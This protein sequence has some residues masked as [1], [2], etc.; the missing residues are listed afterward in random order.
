[1]RA[2]NGHNRKW[3]KVPMET[4]KM[5]TTLLMLPFVINYSISALARFT[6]TPVFISFIFVFNPNFPKNPDSWWTSSFYF[7]LFRDRIFSQFCSLCIFSLFFYIRKR[8][9]FLR[10]I[11]YCIERNIAV[12]KL[13]YDRIYCFYFPIF[14]VMEQIWLDVSCFLPRFMWLRGTVEK[15]LDSWSAFGRWFSPQTGL[16]EL[17]SAWVVLI[18]IN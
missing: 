5:S 9:S 2:K 18:K 1:M 7:P 6:I 17:A 10:K 12:G 13:M 4:G 14:H 15:A 8:Y 16:R 11:L 3:R